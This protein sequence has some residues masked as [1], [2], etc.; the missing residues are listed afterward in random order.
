MSPA[1]SP[2]PEPAA[3]APAAPAAGRWSRALTVA[4]VALVGVLLVEVLFEGWIQTLVG[5][6]HTDATGTVV[7]DPPSWPKHLKNALYLA[8]GALTLAKIVIDRRWRE[9]RTAADGALA[10]LGV[11]MLLAGLLGG[12]SPSLIGEA[13]FVYFRGVIVFY[14]LRAAAPTMRQL[15]PVIWIVAGIV[16]L[17]AVIA[18]VQMAVGKPA[19]TGLRWTEL[20]WANT[21]RAQALLTHPN[22]L[23][24]LLSLSLL[25]LLAWMVTRPA[26]R[27]QWWLLFGTLALALSATQSRESMVAVSVSAGVIWLLARAGGRRVIAAV[28]AIWMCTA[29]Q[30][31]IRPTNRAEW[32]RRLT[33][34]VDAFRVPSG[35]EPGHAPSRSAGW[36]PSAAGT[37]RRP[38]TS[39][40]GA[41][42]SGSARPGQSAKPGTTA[43]S[44]RP[45]AV[46]SAASPRP[47]TSATSAKPPAASGKPPAAS[48][49]PRPTTPARETR[50]LFYQQ[51]LTLF[52]HRPLLGY[53]L[54]QLGGIVAEKNNPDWAH[55]PKF[56]PKGFD[57][58]GFKSQQIDTF[59]LH[60]LVEAGALGMLAYV[61][62]LLLLVEPL[63]RRI[64]RSPGRDGSRRFDPAGYLAIGA[65]V[66][67]FQVAFF[68]ASLEDPM[69]PALL[70]AILGVAWLAAPPGPGG[71]AEPDGGLSASSEHPHPAD[72]AG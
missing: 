20:K 17:N 53:G 51:G 11:V 38:S 6:R 48:A 69:L 36:T 30:I 68:A 62:W 63:W 29:L 16:A 50:V 39:P 59:W 57:R 23:G 2:H 65:L 21:N 8:L 15:R 12:S 28:V 67:G 41:R 43:P 24:H 13:M 55:N 27:Y 44:G 42:P 49:K 45:G 32:E 72:E 18:L 22:H 70:F 54:G 14:A 66:F 25:G 40:S 35:S 10:V 31:A 26:L 4:L 19:F 47:V 33:G 5:G 56:G 58:H 46:T 7:L 71:P 9:F 64:R 3:A 61:G 60:L 1:G 52:T 34:V 37:S